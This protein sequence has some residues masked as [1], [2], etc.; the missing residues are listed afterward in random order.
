MSTAEAGPSRPHPGPRA[1]QQ[2]ELPGGPRRAG[3][4]SELRAL[5]LPELRSLR[6]YAQ[7]EEADLSYVRRLLQG[8]I[9]ILR[10]ELSRR[11]DPGSPLLDL[12]PEI[13]ADEPS[14]HRSSA[15]HVTLGTPR[16]EQYRQLAEQMLGE[17]ELSDVDARTESE[18][19]E[20]MARLVRYERRVSGERHSLQETADACSKEIAHRYRRGEARVDDLLP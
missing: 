4:P 3:A 5:D 8:R 19:Q 6:D 1:P 18:L 11:S 17:V 14:T 12:L 10:A 13:L 20:A 7:R 15:R 9:D 2:R 16:T